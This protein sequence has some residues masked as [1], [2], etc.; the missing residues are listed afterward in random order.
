MPVKDGAPG[1]RKH[2]IGE[3]PIVG[4][5]PWASGE[6]QPGLFRILVARAPALV[7]D[8]RTTEGGP[9]G[10]LELKGKP[11]QGKARWPFVNHDGFAI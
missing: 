6:V 4:E 3:Q 9:L 8:I 2:Q 1:V 7:W 10:S 5:Q 11:P